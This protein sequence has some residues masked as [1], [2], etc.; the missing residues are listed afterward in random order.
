MAARLRLFRQGPCADLFQGREQVFLAQEQIRMF[1][2]QGGRNPILFP[3]VE[4]LR[5]PLLWKAQ[6]LGERLA[7]PVLCNDDFGFIHV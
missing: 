5:Q 3:V 2:L 4:T 6:L 7:A 1:Q